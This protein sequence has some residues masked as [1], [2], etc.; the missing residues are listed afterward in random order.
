MIRVVRPA[1]APPQ[2]TAEEAKRVGVAGKLPGARGP[3]V[4]KRELGRAALPVYQ[5]QP[6]VPTESL[7]GYQVARPALQAAQHFKC[8]YC[9]WPQSE[10]FEP[11]DHFRPKASY[12]WL[13]WRWENL[14]FCC[15]SCNNSR[16]TY[17]P[18]PSEQCLQPRDLPPGSE[19]PLLVDP[20]NW[21]DDDPI[22]HIE[23][24]H[25]G[26]DNWRPQPRAGS[27]RGAEMIAAFDLNRRDLMDRYRT[28]ASHFKY[29]IASI[30]TA[31]ESQN[32]DSIKGI[33][34]DVARR[35]LSSRSPLAALHHDML[36]H[37][38]PE[39]TRKRHS[40]D[41]RIRNE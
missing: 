35:H 24:R 26:D 5:P 34:E 21:A 18:L 10:K 39:E 27:R 19:L 32:P 2:L 6:L 14:L 20:A 8:C 36:A 12:W 9:E 22:C 33:W 4:A 30:Q 28:A 23:Y 1:S 29:A 37:Y 15:N 3:L 31:V 25:E 17:F 7:D 38:F 40:L 41:L 13:A 11:V 16:G